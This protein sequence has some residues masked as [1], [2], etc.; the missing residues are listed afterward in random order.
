MILLIEAIK[1]VADGLSLE[2]CGVRLKKKKTD[3]NSRGTGNRTK[4]SHL[5]ERKLGA[6][7]Q[8]V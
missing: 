2:F 7:Y 5:R 1:Q 4:A 3:A 6:F 8:S